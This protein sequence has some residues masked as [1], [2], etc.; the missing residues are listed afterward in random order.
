MEIMNNQKGTIAIITAILLTA[1]LGFVAL[2]VDTGNLVAS[3]N[4]LQNAADA[5]AL[6]GASYFYSTNP[7]GFTSTSPDPDWTAAEAA[8]TT[9][10][11]ANKSSG[12]VLTDYEVESGYWNLAH[13]PF[14]L[15]SKGITPGPKDAPAVKVTVR[16]DK[17]SNSGPVHN[18][19]AGI[20]GISTSNMSATAT[21]VCA[22]PGTVNPGALLP[23]AIP[24]WIADK[25]D[26]YNSPSNIVTI[27]SAYHYVDDPYNDALAGQ[28]T[29]FAKDDNSASTLKKLIANGNP[30]PLSVGDPIYIQ[31]GTMAVGYHKNY[32][33]SYV[34]K[35]VVLPLVDVVLRPNVKKYTPIHAFIGFH[36][37]ELIKNKGFKGYFVED[38]N[39]G[40]GGASGPYYGTYSPPKLV[41]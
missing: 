39:V 33:G 12:I 37:T 10:S 29:S 17:E 26:E 20:M 35:N 18:F 7:S 6:S 31:P 13:N 32:I 23:V 3:K 11:P 30:D 41:Q 22:S 14:G 15:Q 16:R 2:S 1:F 19:F 25:A 21:A 8:V 27:G 5:A 4:E 38:M 9:N 24:K 28:W 36:I 40:G 34:N